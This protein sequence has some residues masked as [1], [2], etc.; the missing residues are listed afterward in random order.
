MIKNSVKTAAI[1]IFI[2]AEKFGQ[3]H[4]F[5]NQRY[6]SRESFQKFTADSVERLDSYDY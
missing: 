4:R 1:E 5:G 2:C 6:K 3:Y